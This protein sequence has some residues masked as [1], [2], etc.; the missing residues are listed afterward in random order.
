MGF[1][2]CTKAHKNQRKGR[3]FFLNAV[4]SAW[5]LPARPFCLLILAAR[6][7]LSPSP[8]RQLCAIQPSRGGSLSKIDWRWH[9]SDHA[10]GVAGD[11]SD[12]NIYFKQKYRRR[13]GVTELCSQAKPLHCTLG[14]HTLH[15]VMSPYYWSFFHASTVKH[16]QVLMY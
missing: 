11:F 14:L 6:P 15:M 2:C 12:C 8:L 5:M 9:L 4:G 3:P 16:Y 1:E 13:S 10:R 7:A